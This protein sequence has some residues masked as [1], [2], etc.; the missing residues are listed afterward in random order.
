MWGPS[1]LRWPDSSSPTI[2]TTRILNLS[3]KKLRTKTTPF[4]QNYQQPRNSSL[5]RAKIKAIRSTPS[6]LL[7][8]KTT[9]T[10]RNRGSRQ[11]SQTLCS[12]NQRARPSNSP[13]YAQHQ[14]CASSRAQG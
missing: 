13:R 1:S 11:F 6:L 4:W 5:Y 10:L 12:P 3:G 8:Q 9:Q 7:C 2:R 14:A